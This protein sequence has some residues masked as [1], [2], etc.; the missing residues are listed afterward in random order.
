[1]PVALTPSAVSAGTYTGGVSSTSALSKPIELGPGDLDLPELMAWLATTM[2]RSDDAI[3]L[4]MADVNAKKDYA[5]KLGEV[6]TALTRADNVKAGSDTGRECKDLPNLKDYASQPWFQ[7]L[8][9]EAQKAYAD[10][11]KD[12][13]AGGDTIADQGAVKT[14]L[15]AVSGFIG[16]LTSQNETS[17]IRLQSAIASRGQAIQ[18]ISNMVN[19]F[20]EVD[21]AIVG[22]IR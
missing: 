5:A 18:L 20:N 9:P 4:Q 19:S 16:T 7:N 12:T 22:N 8:P 11:C 10:L 15:Q 1:M 13:L 17:M 3:R 14:A 6:L 21:K 2:Q